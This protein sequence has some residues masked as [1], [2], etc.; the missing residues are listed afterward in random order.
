MGK[1][2]QAIKKMAFS[3]FFNAENKAKIIKEL[4]KQINIPLADEKTEK[5]LLEGCYEAMEVA[6]K[7]M[8]EGE[9]NKK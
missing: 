9:N 1:I 6:F 5:M 4:N 8:I 3:M 7:N 2:I